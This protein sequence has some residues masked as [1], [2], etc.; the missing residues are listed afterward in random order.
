MIRILPCFLLVI[1]FISC[2]RRSKETNT[3]NKTDTLVLDDYSKKFD[4]KF[5]V[6]PRDYSIDTTNSYSHFFLDSLVVNTFIKNAELSPS[7]ANRITGFYNKRNYQFAWFS[8]DGPTEQGRGF[9][10]MYS[11]YL[12]NENS[13]V[14]ADSNLVKQMNRYMDDKS[15]DWNH[16]NKDLIATEMLLTKHFI[17][18]ALKN[19]EQWFVDGTELERFVPAKKIATEKYAENLL[20]SV[21]NFN[22]NN[23]YTQLKLAL[24]KYLA[25]Q[26]QG[27]WPAV[28]NFSTE[29]SPQN[30]LLKKR[31]FLSGDLPLMD[32]SNLFTDSLLQAVKSFQTRHGYSATGKLTKAQLAGLNI[33]VEERIQQ[34]LINMSR[35]LWFVNKPQ[36]KIIN[37]NIPAFELIISD[38]DSAVLNMNVVVGKEGSKTTMFTGNM[39]RIVF[40]PY[41]NVPLS[42]TKNEVA[43]GIRR[44]GQAYLNRQN[45]EVIGSWGN[46]LPK[47][48]QKPGGRNSLGKIKFLFP[49]NYD[50]YFHDTPSKSLFKNDKRAY[51]H[52]C[53]RLSDP[54]KL[55]IYLLQND[56]TFTEQKIDSFMNAKVERGIRLKPSIPVMISY[57][58]AW[59]DEAGKLHFANDVYGNDKALAKKMFGIAKKN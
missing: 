1:L 28:T 54:K 19:Y 41:W 59:V 52:G 6:S 18:Y 10:N 3:Q 17:S 11:Y 36:G 21:N 46:G 39:N 27:G 49:N 42:I 5:P 32:S 7:L 15:F 12:Q 31:L 16:Q 24:I 53:I 43:P 8:N 40:S 45:M 55:A 2:Q 22:I 9:W 47:V 30:F 34:L 48:R 14:V 58:T 57:Y 35:A 44:S 38:N 51:S 25:I 13:K 4:E 56:T 33:K 37:V 29:E 23:S 20:A 50:I 26:K